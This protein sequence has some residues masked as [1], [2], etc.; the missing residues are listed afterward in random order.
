MKISRRHFGLA[1]GALAFNS[2]LTGCAS[3]ASAPEIS[4]YVDLESLTADDIRSVVLGL[5]NGRLPKTNAEKSS[6]ATFY[7]PNG[8]DDTTRLARQGRSKAQ[9]ETEMAARYDAELSAKVASWYGVGFILRDNTTVETDAN[10]PRHYRNNKIVFN[11]SEPF[12]TN[13]KYLRD[14]VL[15]TQYYTADELVERKLRNIAIKER[16]L[17][18]TLLGMKADDGFNIPVRNY[19]KLNC[20][21]DYPRDKLEILVG[22]GRRLR[23]E[24]AY[25]LKLAPYLTKDA[26][27]RPDPVLDF[28]IVD[29]EYSL[30]SIA[31]F[32]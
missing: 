32:G 10:I 14:R 28:K 31:A 11:F 23:I 24:F 17:D 16:V 7:A 1:T 9:I 15:E 25:N 2:I 3:T 21:L 12:L 29:A 20:A 30:K 4:R 19:L 13:A 22:Q 8:V 26:N 27:G 5:I 18:R 6:I